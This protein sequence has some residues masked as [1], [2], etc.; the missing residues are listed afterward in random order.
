MP[1][2]FLTRHVGAEELSEDDQDQLLDE[3]QDALDINDGTL[4]L[5][6]GWGVT[7][8]DDGR[9]VEDDEDYEDDE[10]MDNNEE[11]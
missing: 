11:G 9:D 5:P 8:F 4:V 1:V 10:P 7:I 2:I 6:A 3:I